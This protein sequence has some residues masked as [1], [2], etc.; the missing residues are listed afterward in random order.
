MAITRN[1]LFK[2]YKFR[3]EQVLAG[4]QA[5]GQLNSELIAEIDEVTRKGRTS[6]T[7]NPYFMST[8]VIGRMREQSRILEPHEKIHPYAEITKGTDPLSK[9]LVEITAIREPIKLAEEIR[10]LQKNDKLGRPVKEVQFLALHN[11]ISLSARVGE[12]FAIEMLQQVPTALAFSSPPGTP[13]SVDLPQKQGELMERALFLAGHFD[14]GE[15]A[16]KLINEFS[17]LIRSK[18]DEARFK[19]INVVA[20]QCLRSLKKLGMRDEMDRFLGKL[21]TEALR[22]ASLANLK[23]KYLSKPE[24][25][26]MVLQTLQNLATGW[27]TFGLHDQARPL[28]EE[29]RNELLNPEAVKLEAKLYVP[30]SC[31]YVTAC[32]QCP[33][34]EGLARITELFRKMD[35][36]RVTNTWTTS[37][38]YSRFHL[39]LVEAVI[40]AIVSDEYTLGLGGRRWL[41]DDEYLVRRRIHADMKRERVKS[42]L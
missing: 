18:P 11:L 38:F 17:D 10:A 6:G 14:R 34:D 35:P 39:N 12:S 41:D 28:L 23:K 2:A 32:G 20:G 33:S 22:G 8:F 7:N 16:K 42:G 26:G 4:K 31:A 25:W 9:K 15:L 29:A 21:R 27:L 40:Q 3:I 19:L 30:L 24:L 1:F 37:Q 5:T 13:E 36:S